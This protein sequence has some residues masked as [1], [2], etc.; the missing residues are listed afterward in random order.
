M[1]ENGIAQMRSINKV[2]RI[3]DTK[4]EEKCYVKMKYGYK[5]EFIDL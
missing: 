4:D 5:K 2:I 1:K 3:L